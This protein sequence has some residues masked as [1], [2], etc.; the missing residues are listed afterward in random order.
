MLEILVLCGDVP[1]RRP[2]HGNVLEL[3]VFPKADPLHRAGLEL[4]AISKPFVDNLP[5]VLA[6][7]LEVAAYIYAADRLIGR[8]STTLTEM[9]A[10]WRR[11]IRFK[12]AV[13]RL[14]LWNDHEVQAALV[15]ALGFLSE[16]IYGFEFFQTERK[17]GIQPYL[18]FSDP[19]AQIIDPDA[20]VLF[21]GGLDSTAGLVEQVLGEGNRIAFVTHR[22]AKLLAGRQSDLV[23]QLRERAPKRS[24][25]SYSNMGDERRTGTC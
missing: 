8:G 24:L 17:T 25:F 9:G 12:I 13:R 11:K 19:Q 6:D 10:D 18:G 14:A 1:R 5:D 22:S 15:D 21:S 16:D 3:D 2:G 7:M 4:D 20:V 23:I